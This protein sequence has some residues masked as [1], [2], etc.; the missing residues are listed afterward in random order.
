[1]V[2]SVDA[3]VVGGGHNGLV[4]ANLLAD[5]GWS[6]VV[7]EAAD[8][9]GGAV[10]SAGMTAPGF[11]NDLCSAFYP[12]AAV[13]PVIAALDLADTGLRWRHAPHVLAHVFDDSRAAILD[14][15]PMVTAA[16]VEEF[17]AGD[18]DR[19]LGEVAGWDRMSSHLIDA[20]FTPF[21]P[22]RSATALAARLGTADTVRL[23]R[24]AVLPVR[25]LTDEAFRGP[26]AAM[27]VAGCALHTDLPPNEAGSGII[28]WLLAM[29]GQ[30]HG[31]PVPEGG[32]GRLADALVARLE[33]AGGQ[34]VCGAR[35]QRVVVAHGR[36]IG[37]ATS[38]GRGWRARRAVIADVDAPT[39]YG[40]LV[41]PRDLPPRL[42]ADLDNFAWDHGTVK[43]DWAL[44][45][46][47]PWRDP[48]T[49]GAGTIHLD[50]DMAQLSAY[51]QDLADH[52][53]PVRPFILAGQMSTADPSRSPAGTESMWAYTH[54]P[55]RGARRPR[56][57]ADE[58]A[59]VAERV[60]DVIEGHAPG[61][62]RLVIGRRVTG[63]DDLVGG[64]SSLFGGAVGGGT[65]S[66]YQQLVFRP[67][68]GLGRADTPIDRLYLGSSSA[69]PG[70]GV[71][72]GPGANAAR[73]ALARN[74][75]AGGAAYARVMR[76]LN[77]MVY[78]ESDVSGPV[79]EGMRWPRPND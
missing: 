35:T 13:S 25:R 45:G 58:I 30:R 11:V 74:R 65:S 38:D 42:V 55:Q 32:A 15:D 36:A 69:H 78:R 61:F 75:P 54:V 44:S 37:V 23:A 29:V 5:T 57:P 17:A 53:V 72:G 33:K 59:G 10:H 43:I 9:P 63:P 12:F 51:T 76:R 40:E 73:A 2:T 79:Q 60:E 56:W 66:V 22:V 26:G 20:L 34:I 47:V 21:P 48:R 18:G 28:G 46:P 77:R 49:S 1:V 7:L 70:G 14:R 8:R 24:R 50:G 62:R 68:P 4:A 64:N 67:V 41:E 39:L 6:V 31:F 27:L 16:S 3:V 52:R 19:W 71:H